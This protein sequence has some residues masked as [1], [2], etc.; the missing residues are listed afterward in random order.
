MGETSQ[1]TLL[2]LSNDERKGFGSSTVHKILSW[3]ATLN[4]LLTKWRA[5]QKSE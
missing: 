1:E 2:V 4:Y 5:Q 3:Q